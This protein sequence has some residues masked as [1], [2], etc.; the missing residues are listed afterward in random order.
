MDRHQLKLF[1]N[2]ASALSLRVVAKEGVS[3]DLLLYP[4]GSVLLP[5][6]KHH[7][8]ILDEGTEKF[9]A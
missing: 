9:A 2:L 3:P 5:E 7:K 1:E 8:E 6:R 4:S